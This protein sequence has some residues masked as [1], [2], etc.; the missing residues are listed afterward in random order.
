ML[1]VLN[2]QITSFSQKDENKIDIDNFDAS[3]ISISFPDAKI[4]LPIPVTLTLD[5]S[6]PDT[7]CVVRAKYFTSKR[8]LR[9]NFGLIDLVSPNSNSSKSQ[10]RSKYY[11]IKDFF[12]LDMETGELY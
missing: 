10:T 9:A 5:G 4:K 12:L 7:L 2:L 6:I 11:I 3:T 8:N 1:V